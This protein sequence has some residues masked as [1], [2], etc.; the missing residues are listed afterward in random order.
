[1]S[2]IDPTFARDATEALFD[3]QCRITRDLEGPADD[4]FDPLTGTST[5]PTPD[6]V[7]VYAGPCRFRPDSRLRTAEDQG[8]QEIQQTRYIARLPIAIIWVQPGDLFICTTSTWD[9]QQAGTECVVTEVSV[10]STAVTRVVRMAVREK[11][12][13]L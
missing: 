4:T 11:A 13:R 10:G 2:L 5:T 6:S 7:L 9:G 12:P 3:C 8:G 1:M